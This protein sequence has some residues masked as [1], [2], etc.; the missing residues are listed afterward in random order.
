MLHL[1]C[2]KR[3]H[4]SGCRDAGKVCR[5]LEVSIYQLF[6][7][8]EE[9]PKLPVLAKPKAGSDIAWGSNGEDARLVAKFCNLFSRMEKGDLG[10][11]LFMAQKMARRKAV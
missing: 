4:S 3:I 8:G 1:P 6:Y 11:V 2:R 7:D 10:L 5:V 9:P